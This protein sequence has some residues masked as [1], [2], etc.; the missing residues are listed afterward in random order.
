MKDLTMTD[1]PLARELAGT[2]LRDRLMTVVETAAYLRVSKSYL[3]KARLSG[4]GP[5]FIKIG[6][7]IVYRV[8]DVDDWLQQRQFHSTSQYEV[9]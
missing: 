4:D 1:T 6:R 5:R 9:A 8:I 7:K 3:D 2:A